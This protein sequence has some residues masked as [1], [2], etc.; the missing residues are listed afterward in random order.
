MYQLTLSLL[1]IIK[2][3]NVIVTTCLFLL[4]IGMSAVV[5][6]EESERPLS[7]ITQ[8][9]LNKFQKIDHEAGF[10][11][12]YISEFLLHCSYFQDAILAYLHDAESLEDYIQGMQH[13]D[14][15]MRSFRSNCQYATSVINFYTGSF[16]PPRP[17]FATIKFHD[18]SVEGYL[19]TFKTG[20][21]LSPDQRKGFFE[22]EMQKYSRDYIAKPFVLDA[23]TIDQLDVESIYNFVLLPDGIILA[24][25]ERPGD[26][27]YH[28]RED[29]GIVEAFQYPNHTILAGNPD[30]VVVTAG[31]FIIYQVDNKRLFYISSKSGHFQPYY[32]SLVHM[33]NQ[34]AKLG[35]NPFTVIGTPDVNISEVL[36]KIYEKAQVP[37][38]IATHEAGRLF[39]QAHD[40]W[41]KI[42]HE[43]DKSILYKLAQGDLTVLDAQIIAW[44]NRQREEA[45]YMRSA[46]NLFSSQHEP[47][48][49]FH[50][51]VKRFGK[52]KDAIK[53]QV[54]AR[55]QS[56]ATQVLDLM[57]QY[58]A[59]IR[60][61]EFVSADTISFYN[62]LTG[63]IKLMQEL[64][65]KKRLV[66]H[67]YH[68]LK[69]L[70]RELGTLFLYL[71]DDVKWKGKRYFM[72]H[73]ASKAFF[74]INEIMGKAH[75]AY[76]AQAMLGKLDTTEEYYVELSSKIVQQLT[77]YLRHLDVSPPSYAIEIDPEE[78]W[79]MI[80]WSKDWYFSHYH[81]L[82]H[83][84]IVERENL[85]DK[86]DRLHAYQILHAIV[87]GD[88]EA[89]KNKFQS[90][91]SQF[92][93]IK[94]DAEVAR[95]A[96][97]FLDVS[98]QVP[99]VVHTYI[100][101]LDRII[102]ALENDAVESVTEDALWMIDCCSQGHPTLALENWVC[103]DQASFNTTLAAYL[104]CLYDF[105][106]ESFI[107]R[108]R[109]E[110]IVENMQAFQ[111]LINLFRRN[112]IS[113][114]KDRVQINLPA[115][116]YDTLEENAE[117]LLDAMRH[118]LK[119]CPE[120]L[121][122]SPQMKVHAAF[123]LSKVKI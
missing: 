55:I 116:C 121:N 26:R 12:S 106:N 19:N 86:K 95:N 94:R 65:S 112:G 27:E 30:Q 5:Q 89:Q 47:P 59:E 28:A 50:N 35:V 122:V 57:D 115:V 15:H 41:N 6:A 4:W 74:Q 45:T 114:R 9:A 60:G 90:A 16:Q 51:L 1:N 108:Q 98:H 22:Q 102:K 67:E 104:S 79:W 120:G 3:K 83:P 117:A 72:Y 87:D 46:Y 52:L 44:L 123:I 56:E 33:R 53:H 40:R 64:L 96:L 21:K 63:N 61:H 81:Y 38:S 23:A 80:N 77:R 24:A 118:E 2:I 107:S 11:G 14:M 29:E 97:I 36:L 71:S 78:A 32:S 91:Q 92:G 66:V 93:W 54:T 43:V 34:L 75:D 8:V 110:A 88:Y 58:E 62:F 99:E 31:A 73:T 18:Q 103:T 101:H 10:Y 100:E 109:A 111:D 25:P 20:R 42:Y 70:S 105:K 39:Q 85:K 69:K 37:I 48:Q 84:E 7:P 68:Q 17:Q 49:I 113:K 119:A 13:L 76:V 82:P